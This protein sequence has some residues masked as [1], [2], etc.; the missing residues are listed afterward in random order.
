MEK[1]I[2][3]LIVDDM[4]LARNR[5]RRFLNADADIEVI[6]ECSDGKGAVAAVKELAPDMI[7]LDVQ[8]PEMD[9]FEVLNSIGHEN[10]PAIIFVTAHDQYALRAFDV[11]AI[12]YLLKPFDEHRFRRALE[13]AKREIRQG[14]ASDVDER[15]RTLLADVS[16]EP[17]YMKRMAVKTAGRTVILATDEIDWIGTAGNYLR[18]H[19]GRETHLIRDRMSQLESRLDPK[20]FAR[21][22]RSIIVNVDRVK[23]MHPLFNGD[24][25]LILRDGT[26]L[27]MSRTYRDKLLTLLE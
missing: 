8:M 9:G 12:D 22:H 17:K 2:R 7:F 23:E 11:H 1:K 15:L 27:T 14:Q 4:P 13:R 6:G 20:Q 10:L 16:R 19:A 5:V 18:L 3:T 24:Q 26:Q 25:V 21:V